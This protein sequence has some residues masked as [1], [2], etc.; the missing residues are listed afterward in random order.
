MSGN[1]LKI[2]ILNA[3]LAAIYVVITMIFYS[4]SFGVIQVRIATAL[5]QLVAFN[6]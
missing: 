2:I 1:K 3:V 6:K 5:Y 4:F